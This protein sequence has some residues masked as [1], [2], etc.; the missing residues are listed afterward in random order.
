MTNRQRANALLI[1]DNDHGQGFVALAAWNPNP[2]H[3]PD[4]ALGRPALTGGGM[5]AATS[6]RQIGDETVRSVYLL[7]IKGRV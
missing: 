5:A 7:L 4:L 1:R 6:M 3:R 2:H